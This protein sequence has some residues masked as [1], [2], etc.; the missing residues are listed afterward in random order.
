MWKPPNTQ[1]LTCVSQAEC[2]WMHTR[3]W[4][5]P[6]ASPA[7]NLQVGLWKPPLQGLRHWS[8]GQRAWSGVSSSC[9]CCHI[10]TQASLGRH[11][12]NPQKRA[13]AGTGS[14]RH[15]CHHESVSASVN[16]G[17]SRH[18]KG[19]HHKRPQQ[20]GCTGTTGCCERAH[21]RANMGHRGCCEIHREWACWLCTRT[22]RWS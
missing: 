15:C 1:S 16:A 9:C 18:H 19:R 20:W 3:H 13:Y 12:K 8:P 5:P 14:R 7:S 4:P 2:H 11:H 17:Q 6:R 22:H 21:P 10:K